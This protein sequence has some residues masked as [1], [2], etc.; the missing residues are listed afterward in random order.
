MKFV[1]NENKNCIFN[2]VLARKISV[3]LV[4]KLNEVTT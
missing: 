1:L 3:E 4:G 2:F